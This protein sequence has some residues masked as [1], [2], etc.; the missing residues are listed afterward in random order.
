MPQP[1]VLDI[2][3]GSRNA[4]AHTT[5]LDLYGG[6]RLH[7]IVL[8]LKPDG[9][10]W[11]THVYNEDSRANVV[12]VCA[13][14]WPKYRKAYR[15]LAYRGETTFDEKDHVYRVDNVPVPGVSELIQMAGITKP[16]KANEY[17]T[18]EQYKHLAEVGTAVHAWIVWWELQIR[19]SPN[20]AKIPDFYH[21]HTM[22][23]DKIPEFYHG[24]IMQWEKFKGEVGF[25]PEDSEV[26]TGGSLVLPGEVDWQL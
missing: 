8:Y 19:G 13:R 23:L 10:E 5:Q 22:Q 18:E 15:N 3:T 14:A 25:V 7:R 11:N 6:E 2:K 9:Y 4:K 12:E 20:N 26:L 17:C 24:H 21:G 16:F 1:A